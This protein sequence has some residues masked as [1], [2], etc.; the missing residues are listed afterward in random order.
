MNHNLNN[1]TSSRRNRQLY[2]LIAMAAAYPLGNM[3]AYNLSH[4]FAGQSLFLL[5]PVS[6]SIAPVIGAVIGIRGKLFRKPYY[7]PGITLYISLLFVL[8]W[9]VG[10]YVFV[11]KVVP[12]MNGGL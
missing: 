8:T 3:L 10:V 9:L 7:H 12:Y 4:Y 6:F 1:A 5:I 11:V 2:W